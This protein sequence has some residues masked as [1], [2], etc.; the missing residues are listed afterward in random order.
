MKTVE[1]MHNEFT[2]RRKL[3]V[4]NLPTDSSEKVLYVC[5]YVCMYVCITTSIYLCM[6]IYIYVHV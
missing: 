4:S 2:E 6:C 5:M 3:I 1:K